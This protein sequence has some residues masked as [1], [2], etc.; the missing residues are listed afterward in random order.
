V[1]RKR[2]CVSVCV[3]VHIYV[4]LHAYPHVC[5]LC[6]HVCIYMYTHTHTHTHT[7]V[8]AAC[9]GSERREIL[10]RLDGVS[11]SFAVSPR[12]GVCVCVCVCVCVVCVCV[13]ICAHMVSPVFRSLFCCFVPL[14]V[15]KIKGELAVLDRQRRPKDQ[16]IWP[17]KLVI[18]PNFDQAV[19]ALFSPTGP[20]K[21]E[22]PPPPAPPGGRGRGGGGGGGGAWPRKR[23]IRM[24]CMLRLPAP[25]RSGWLALLQAS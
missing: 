15:K 11:V 3:C 9:D 14:F 7:Q 1:R 12:G 19:S 5:V 20:S 13:Y 25:W 4:H 24:M 16:R 17:E 22:P 6:I 18:I 2:V 23:A 21:S 10:G 8:L